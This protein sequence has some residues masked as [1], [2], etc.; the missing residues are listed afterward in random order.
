MLVCL[1][2]RLCVRVCDI[3]YHL[4]RKGFL[5]KTLL[6]VSSGPL[7]LHYRFFPSLFADGGR[8]SV[9]LREAGEEEFGCRCCCYLFI[10]Y[11]G[12]YYSSIVF[13][14]F[15]FSFFISWLLFVVKVLIVN[16]ISSL[17]LLLVL[18]SSWLSC[19]YKT[20]V[21]SLQLFDSIIIF[22]DIISLEKERIFITIFTSNARSPRRDG[23]S[24]G[25]PFISFRRISVKI[26]RIYIYF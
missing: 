15:L 20:N 5:W 16:I 10:F 11:L 19:H 21:F 22:L 4:V 7:P 17:V 9:R 24:H 6:I 13:I 14:Y 25:S 12:V 23:R 26:V 2:I 3:V 18:L 1:C 8:V